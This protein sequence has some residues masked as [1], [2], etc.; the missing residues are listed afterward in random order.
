[1]NKFRKCLH[2][3]ILLIIT[4]NTGAQNSSS[5]STK[6]NDGIF[7]RV[8][9]AFTYEHPKFSI[10][11]Y[12]VLNYTP[13]RGVGFGFT[14]IVQILPDTSKVV[15]EFYRPT[16][17]VPYLMISTKGSLTFES[18]LIAFT[19]NR[20]NMFL[21]MRYAEYPNSFFGIGAPSN[22]S[23]PIDYTSKDLMLIGEI[24]KGIGKVVF[25]GVRFDSHRQ[26]NYHFE[27]STVV[28]KAF[29]YE[30]GWNTG[31]G[32][33]VKLDT[34][35]DILYPTKGWFITAFAL[36]NSTKLGGDYKYSVYSV[37]IRKYLTLPG[38]ENVLALQYVNSI[39]K[40][41]APF[42]KMP[43]LAGSI[44]L[45]GISHPNKYVDNNRWVLQ[46]EY[47]KHLFWRFGTAAF[48]AAGAVY[49]SETNYFN[50]TQAL[51]GLGFRFRIV[52][53][54]RLN[55]RADYGFATNGDRAFYMTI[56]E[57]F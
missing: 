35:N 28:K 22:D 36:F 33:V 8:T 6:N 42:Y 26:E 4:L 52:P 3:I 19:N 2:I 14:P 44:L 11:T 41:S 40:G 12:P 10:S 7:E 24:A 54:D 32:P 55:F 13:D 31:L 16:T 9:S 37:D 48:V 27:D 20:W 46:A 57:A 18:D 1:M 53:D 29:G 30:G 21:R 45:R 56:R 43:K 17:I 51:A 38:N 5:D 15:S 50:N 49:S 47:R 34:R 39:T 23:L 25:I